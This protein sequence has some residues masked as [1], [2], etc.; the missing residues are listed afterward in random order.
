[1]DRSQKAHEYAGALV[2]KALTQTCSE[3]GTQ[4]GMS[5]NGTDDIGELPQANDATHHQQSL[6]LP[7]AEHKEPE[8][9][10]ATQH[11]E[12]QQLPTAQ[13]KEPE[14]GGATQHQE[15]QQ[16]PT[17]QHK[18]PEVGGATQH[19]EPQQ[20]P[21]AQHEELQEPEVGES[22]AVVEPDSTVTRPRIWVGR[23]LR[24][25]GDYIITAPFQEISPCIYAFRVGK[26]REKIHL[27]DV[28]SP[29]DL[30]HSSTDN[31]YRLRTPKTEIHLFHSP[32]L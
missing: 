12:P 1:M 17:A 3:S 15:P 13:H 23:C 21:T 31:T 4:G 29:I 18:E 20:L 19:Q 8:T 25:D 28:V 9:G 10:G 27:K 14:V 6:H 30:V 22:V 26:G 32:Q 5:S 24:V 7:T 11:Q 2:Q 16:L